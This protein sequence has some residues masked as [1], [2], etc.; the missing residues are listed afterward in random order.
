M[1]L[2][3][4]NKE[5]NVKVS[6]NEEEMEKGLQ[7]VKELAPN[8]G[9]LFIFEEPE[10]VSFWMKDTLIDLDIIF[11]DEDKE[12]I[13]IVR[14]EAGNDEDAFEEDDV[15]YVL[16]IAAGNH[17]FKPGMEVEFEETPSRDEE[18]MHVLDSNGETQMVLKGGERIFSRKNT[19]ILVKLA[20]D[21]SEKQTD[22]A[23]KKLGKKIFQYLDIQDD[24]EP[25][26]VSKKDD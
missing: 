18:G 1:K 20:K 11:I 16:E 22:N 8:E 7:G 15:K 10:E 14:G 4:K 24:N 12:I 13:D 2:K 3:I 6:R 26:Y 9:M 5:F 25:E 19:R 23:Y 17:K 21:A